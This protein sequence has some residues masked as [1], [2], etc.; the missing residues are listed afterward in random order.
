MGITSGRER[1]QTRSLWV[2]MC[3][4][5]RAATM[6][7]PKG[8]PLNSGSSSARGAP[9]SSLITD[10]TSQPKNP[11][12]L[13]NITN[14]PLPQ[15]QKSGSISAP[16]NEPS[17]KEDEDENSGSTTK[18]ARST[19]RGGVAPSPAVLL[20]GVTAESSAATVVPAS[21][22][23]ESAIHTQLPTENKWVFFVS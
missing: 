18:T 5:L 13:T 23:A 12:G 7:R 16:P 2:I 19:T 9:T 17:I 14:A 3:V 1:L 10:A 11:M 22:I 20:I 15:L 6:Q 8:S 21:V 4:P